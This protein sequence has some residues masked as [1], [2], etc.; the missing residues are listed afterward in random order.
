[1][2]NEYMHLFE[3]NIEQTRILFSIEKELVKADI[4]ASGNNSSSHSEKLVAL[5]REWLNEWEASIITILS[6][7]STEIQSSSTEISINHNNYL[8]NYQEIL[9][10]IAKENEKSDNTTWLYM[11]ILEA[12]LFI[13]YSPLDS[14]LKSDKHK[15]YFRLKYEDQRGTLKDILHESNL[16]EV[17][18]IDRYAKA[19][20]RIIDKMEGKV[21]KYVIYG[22]TV[23]LST[24]ALA[25][26]AGAFVIQIAIAIYGPM[27][28]TLHGAALI[29]AC[30]AAAGG[31]A[32]AAGGGGMVAGV[33]F[34]VGGGA[35]IG[36]GV[37]TT[38]VA[39]HAGI[40]SLIK[41]IVV[42]PKFALIQAAKLYVAITEI[43]I[44]K[45]QNIKVA[46]EFINQFRQQIANLNKEIKEQEL[47]FNKNKDNKKEINNLKKSLEYMEKAYKELLRFVSSF[48]EGMNAK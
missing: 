30:L 1:M 43:I 3:L 31:G 7:K 44:N 18:C 13:P 20:K 9:E 37:G 16:I 33:A 24:A 28:P 10:A 47:K 11:V 6:I 45:Q 34:I 48:E 22:L 12:T 17:D 46:Y 38:G 32:I 25:A 5:K 8:Y 15:K 42:S 39:A 4:K 19:Y 40:N 26:F 36:A 35:L 41:L 2:T 29:T 23:A 14:D 21:K 27:F